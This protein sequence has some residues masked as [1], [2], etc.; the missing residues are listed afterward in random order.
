MAA[1]AEP[2]CP[3]DPSLDG[4]GAGAAVAADDLAVGAPAQDGPQAEDLAQALASI[5]LPRSMLKRI[6]RNAAPE[7]RFSSEAVAGLHRIAQVFICF[8]T[9]RALGELKAENDK[10]RKGK[11]NPVLRRTLG[12]DHVMRFLTA[13]L[14]PIASKVS[15]LFPDLVPPEFKPPA[16][17]LLEQLH[18]Q[19]KAFEPSGAQAQGGFLKALAG[20]A[21]SPQKARTAQK[22]QQ[23]EEWTDAQGYDDD[24]LPEA[25]APEHGAQTGKRPREGGV[26]K[27]PK[28]K[29]AKVAVE[30]KA[31]A[32]SLNSFFGRAAPP[33]SN[34]AAPASSAPS[35]DLPD[36]D[37]IPHDFGGAV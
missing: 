17:K 3:L 33:N 37:T 9:D 36:E 27:G 20:A 2:L 18:E 7:A 14:P 22:Q 13:E 26:E 19:E 28:G 16:V 35:S 21:T 25:P 29:K 10:A 23:S 34:S 24:S 5:S 31:P 32:V 11:K 12:A 6:A 30:T 4:V 1:M 8:A 15:N